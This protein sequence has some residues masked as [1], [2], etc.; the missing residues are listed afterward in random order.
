M[1]FGL[2]SLSA[3]TV[4]VFRALESRRSPENR[5][6]ADTYARWFVRPGLRTALRG[7]KP[8]A[9]AH[10]S[11]GVYDDVIARHVLFDRRLSSFLAAGHRHLVLLGAGY[12]T[13]AWRFAESDV[14]ILELDRPRTQ[15]RKKHYLNRHAARFPHAPVEM[16]EVDFRQNGWAACLDRSDLNGATKLFIWEGV[17]MYLSKTH[18]VSFLRALRRVMGPHDRLLFD[19]WSGEPP[20]RWRRY[21][22]DSFRHI[23]EPFSFWIPLERIPSLVR[24][25]GFE[26]YASTALRDVPKRLDKG[27]W[28]HLGAVELCTVSRPSPTA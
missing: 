22:E 2:P 8:E 16:T 6:L 27:R 1:P 11:L 3:E 10:L 21:T 13:R 24:P 4:C 20:G 18:V 17:S 9:V 26:V 25:L 12:D 5:R 15:R 19:V 7:I 23:S 28:G 14:A